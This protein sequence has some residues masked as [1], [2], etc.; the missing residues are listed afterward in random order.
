VEHGEKGVKSPKSTLHAPSK[1]VWPPPHDVPFATL[2][3]AIQVAAPEEQ[4][5]MPVWQTLPAGLHATPGVQLTH[6]PLSQ[7]SL[8]PH[9]VPFATLP[10]A[11][12]IAAPEEHEMMPAWQ[13]LPAG[14]HAT[15]EVQ[16]THAPLSQISLVPHD[17]P[18]ATL[19]S[20]MQVAAPEEHE[21]MPVWQAL[22]AGLHAT[23]EVQLTHE[24]L[25][26]ISLVPHDVP[27]ATLPSAMQV[28]A[29]D[30]HEMM[31]VWQALPA[32]L[33]ATPEVQLTHAPLSQ[34]WLVPHGVPF[35]TLPSATQVAAPEEHEIAPVWQALVGV[36]TTPGVHEVGPAG[37][38]APVAPTAPLQ[39]KDVDDTAPSVTRISTPP[40]GQ[41][42]LPG[43]SW[44]VDT[45]TVG[46]DEP[47][48]PA[49]PVAPV[50]PVGPAGPAGP[51]APV[52]PVAPTGPAGPVAPVG[53]VAPLAP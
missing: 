7:I 23:P 3:S 22:P 50:G 33:H 18:F 47:V 5:M 39:T 45:V 27:F 31:P 6:A 36:H 1:Q 9:D 4:E 46:L 24:P 53:P 12:Q 26:Q 40:V 28:A 20:A 17:V 42:G 10:S 48:P 37:P 15:P 52:G 34:V 32:G 13:T 41:F 11:T 29:P 8:A 19:P 49:G 38:V 30:E 16:L 44:T 14:L 2:P 43:V 51:V 25:S 35:A 21:M